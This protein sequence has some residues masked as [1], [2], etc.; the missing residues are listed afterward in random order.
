M[1]KIRA[2]TQVQASGTPDSTKFLRG[3][4]TWA[5]P[6]GG[7]GSTRVYRS[8][9]LT[10]PDA[11]WTAIGWDNEV[12]DELGIHDNSTNNDRFTI[13]TTG[14]YRVTAQAGVASSSQMALRVMKNGSGGTR[15]AVILTAPATASEI[16]PQITTGTV[17]LTAGD[18]LNVWLIP[19]NT[20]GTTLDGPGADAAW[21]EVERIS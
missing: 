2:S 11:T 15:L 13:A 21:C 1:S 6:G 12:R 7:F 18:Y 5:A 17:D 10:L 9:S 19:F 16:V 3:D 8:A 20:G 4:D 14:R